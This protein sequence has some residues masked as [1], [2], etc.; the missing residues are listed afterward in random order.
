MKQ[1]DFRR[2]SLLIASCVA[3]DD[4]FRHFPVVGGLLF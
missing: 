1:L 4:W 3:A 2:G